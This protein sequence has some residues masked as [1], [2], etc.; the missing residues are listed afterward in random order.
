MN[1]LSVKI[2]NEVSGLRN[3]FLNINRNQIIEKT[4]SLDLKIFYVF[5]NSKNSSSCKNS[6]KKSN[7]RKN[8]S[9]DISK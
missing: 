7:K 3:F 6:S 1:D 2:L 9:S 8:T 4:D 5:E